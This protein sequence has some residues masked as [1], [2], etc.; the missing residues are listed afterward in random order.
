[1]LK[2]KYPGDDQLIK[3]QRRKFVRVEYAID[4]AITQDGFYS[5]YIAEDLSAGGIAIRIPEKDSFQPGEIVS[6]LIVLPFVNQEIK[7]VHADASVVRMWDKSGRKIVS[8]KFEE[9]GKSDRQ[10]IIRFC[11][12]RQIQLRNIQ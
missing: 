7:Y 12:E 5:Q 9:I 2:L 1:M 3:I 8:L 10:S 6:L 11:F 4:V